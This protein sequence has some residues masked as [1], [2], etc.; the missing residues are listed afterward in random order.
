ML[1][2]C[3][4]LVPFS[5]SYMLLTSKTR[6]PLHYGQTTVSLRET[7]SYIQLLFLVGLNA[8]HSIWQK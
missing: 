4:S 1:K 5:I 6:T 3:S 2:V 8:Q 7:R